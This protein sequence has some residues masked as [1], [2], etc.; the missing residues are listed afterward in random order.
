MV[1]IGAALAAGIAIA[2]NIMMRKRGCERAYFTKICIPKGQNVKPYYSTAFAVET[3]VW[4]AAF[5]A[6]IFVA[7]YTSNQFI[8]AAALDIR[9][10]AIPAAAIVA[11]IVCLIMNNSMIADITKKVDKKKKEAQ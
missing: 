5:A 9:I 6:T 8:P 10:L 1:W 3:I 11:E 4:L 2:F 7:V